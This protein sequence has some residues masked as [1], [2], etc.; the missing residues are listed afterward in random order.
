MQRP[1]LLGESETQPAGWASRTWS[2]KHSAG[3]LGRAG[4]LVACVPAGC[5]APRLSASAHLQGGDGL[6]SQVGRCKGGEVG[7]PP[8]ESLEE[9]LG[10]EQPVSSIDEEA[11]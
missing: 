11:T 6:S 7:S 9:T 5:P 10:G 4:L 2:R 3:L 8:K 1:E